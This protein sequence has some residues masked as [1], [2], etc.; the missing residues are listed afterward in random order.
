M[1]EVIDSPVLQC[2]WPLATRRTSGITYTNCTDFTRL[3]PARID[4]TMHSPARK[5]FVIAGRRG[6]AHARI[7]DRQGFGGR[8]LGD[9]IV[10]AVKANIQPQDHSHRSQERVPARRPR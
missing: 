10:K 8:S 2:P 9:L 1:T 6:D 4:E 7:A 3:L 5:F